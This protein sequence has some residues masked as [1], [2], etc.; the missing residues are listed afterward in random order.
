MSDPATYQQQAEY[1]LRTRRLPTLPVVVLRITR[2]PG[3]GIVARELPAAP[4]AVITTSARGFVN[5]LAR[6][7]TGPWLSEATG[8]DLDQLGEIFGISRAPVV[9][10]DAMEVR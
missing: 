7:F 9:D 6:Q 8:R 10:V 4:D 1:L 2:L 3:S 5:A